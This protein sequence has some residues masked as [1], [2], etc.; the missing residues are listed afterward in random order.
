MLRSHLRQRRSRALDQLTLITR[1]GRSTDLHRS[2]Y[3]NLEAAVL[4]FPWP[5]GDVVLDNLI[6]RIALLK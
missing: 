5:P 4:H 2:G 6:D 1:S 3:I